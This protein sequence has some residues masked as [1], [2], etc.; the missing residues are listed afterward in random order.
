M[1]TGQKYKDYLTSRLPDEYPISSIPLSL[2]MTEAHRKELIFNQNVFLD[3]ADSQLNE[4]PWI[5]AIAA[6]K[7]LKMQEIYDTNT[8][9]FREFHEK[10]YFDNVQNKCLNIFKKTDELL[11]SKTKENCVRIVALQTHFYEIIKTIDVL[12]DALQCGIETFEPPMNQPNMLFGFL[13]VILITALPMVIF[14]QEAVVFCLFL[15]IVTFLVLCLIYKPKN[16]K[17]IIFNTLRQSYYSITSNY[18]SSLE[19]DPS[20]LALNLKESIEIFK[21]LVDELNILTD[22]Y[23]NPYSPARF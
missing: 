3:V 17:Y 16:E 1:T 12:N 5:S 21:S 14:G 20:K 15:F 4:M 11:D 7:H 23:I 2:K 9:T 8:S 10:E 6:I 18:S 19:I 13:I 22:T